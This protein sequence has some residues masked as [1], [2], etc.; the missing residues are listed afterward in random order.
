MA[1]RECAFEMAA[2]NIRF[3]AGVTRELG[4]DLKDSGARR[5]LVL[6]DAALAPLPP[7]AAVMQSLDDNGIAAALYDRVR[8]EP[9]DESF[10]DAIAF[11][12]GREIDAFVAVG[13][14]S[15]LDTA[16]AVNLYTCH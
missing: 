5:V 9:T 7:V 2:S 6:T 16:K 3:G 15:V 14:G 12:R 11:A 10:L 13:G 4:M 1:D 8:V